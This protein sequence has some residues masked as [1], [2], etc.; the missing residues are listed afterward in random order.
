MSAPSAR[1]RDRVR[2][3]MNARRGFTLLELLV[4]LVLLAITAAAAVPAFL[5]GG[6]DAPEKRLA[7]A[8][9]DALVHTR[10]A[11]RTSGAAAELV[12]APSDGRYWV[13][14]RDSASAGV[15]PMSAG[16]VIAPSNAG[17]AT[18]RAGSTDRVTLRFDPTGP[19]SPAEI[20][21][22]GARSLTVRVEP[23]TG[24]ISIDDGRTR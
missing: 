8:L 5:D 9:A 11:A 16:V 19:A 15:L 12:L 1:R 3:T 22:R 18:P 21:V 6:T 10:D 20:T 24:E 7:T 17:D 23:W 13:T 14:Q 4:V 2:T